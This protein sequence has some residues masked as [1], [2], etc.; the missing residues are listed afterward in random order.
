MM[1]FTN[2]ARNLILTV[3]LLAGPASAALAACPASS[4]LAQGIVLTRSVDGYAI[5]YR[6]SAG[7]LISRYQYPRGAEP[8]D[9]VTATFAHALLPTMRAGDKGAF[10][11]VYDKPVAGIDDRLADGNDWQSGVTFLI[12]GKTISKGTMDVTFRGR[13]S[14]AL[15]ACHYQAL[16]VET[17]LLLEDTAP[18]AFRYS[19]VPSLGIPVEAIRIDQH[20][21]P[22][23]SV[24]YDSIRLA[25]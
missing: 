5:L 2:S 17:A 10:R 21:N 1:T 6:E 20:G 22:V 23:S 11:F 4:D 12:D 25:R 13:Q 24:T 8:A 16:I 7:E 18:I 15:G 14:V 9:D 3:L 19:Y